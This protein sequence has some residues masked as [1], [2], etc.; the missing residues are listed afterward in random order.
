MEYAEPSPPLTACILSA[1][2][3]GEGWRGGQQ[4][5]AGL[6]LCPAGDGEVL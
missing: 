3:A 4:W 2:P 1:G 6:H 5:D